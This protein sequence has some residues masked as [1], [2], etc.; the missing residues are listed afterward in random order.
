MRLLKR[1]KKSRSEDWWQELED[2]RGE[3]LKLPRN[4]I[5]RVQWYQKAARKDFIGYYVIEIAAIIASAAIPAAAAS[6]ASVSAIAIL[7]AF[8]T[9]LIGVRQLYRLGDEW[10]RVASTLVALEREVVAWSVGVKPYVE[11]QNR[12]AELANR[13]ESIVLMETTRWSTLRSALLAGRTD[14]GDGRPQTPTQGN[15]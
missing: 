9:A 5:E 11:P 13:V 3:K 1:D 12:D 6:G 2:P 14:A 8:V 15:G 7:G 4:V 10:I